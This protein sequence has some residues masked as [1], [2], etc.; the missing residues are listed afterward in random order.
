MSLNQIIQQMSFCSQTISCVFTEDRDFSEGIYVDKEATKGNHTFEKDGFGPVYL[1]LV[2]YYTGPTSLRFRLS[3]KIDYSF[4]KVDSSNSL[5]HC[6]DKKSC[7]L[8]GCKECAIIAHNK[9]SGWN[10]SFSYS[11]RIKLG[12]VLT[13]R[14]VVMSVLLI[15]V[16]I[17]FVLLS[18]VLIRSATSVQRYKETT[19]ALSKQSN[20]TSASNP[21]TP[22]LQG[23]SSAAPVGSS[24]SVPLAS[25]ASSETTSAPSAPAAPEDLPPPY[26]SEADIYGI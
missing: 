16:P 1:R 11:V 26:E 25:P 17:G 10:S 20:T 7:V 19:S 21:S 14:C 18:R 23:N 8:D 15:I 4:F 12:R 2:M 24:Y 22:L 9:G 13:I 6:S 5:D 3:G